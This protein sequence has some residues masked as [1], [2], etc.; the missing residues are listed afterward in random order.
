MTINCLTCSPLARIGVDWFVIMAMFDGWGR[1]EIL[2][3]CF[4]W[5][6]AINHLHGRQRRCLTDQN[7]RKREK[8]GGRGLLS[9]LFVANVGP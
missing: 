8:R 4:F 6:A 7:R 9:P 1:L 5:H 3:R 2:W